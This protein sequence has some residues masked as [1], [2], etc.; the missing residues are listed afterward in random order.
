[1]TFQRN[2]SQT[3]NTSQS[4]ECFIVMPFGKKPGS[5][6]RTYDFD[7]VYRV[8][9]QRAVNG[10]GM[11]PVRSDERIGSRLI[12]SDMFKDL[13]DQ[14]VVLADLSLENP[15]VFYELGVRHVSSKI[16]AF[17]ASSSSNDRDNPSNNLKK[18]GRHLKD[19]LHVL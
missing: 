18:S 12:H 11:R 14:A 13:R 9:I 3:R 19:I 16:E 2:D 8:I 1:M 4:P 15:N 17:Q 5:D 10:A 6:G 7:K